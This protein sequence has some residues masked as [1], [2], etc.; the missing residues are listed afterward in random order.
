MN[1]DTVM[2]R[3]AKLVSQHG[4]QRAAAAAL[5]ISQ[6]H[7]CDMIHGRRRPGPKTLKALGLEE[8]V[9]YTVRKAP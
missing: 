7:F 1:L 5:G 2:E 8:T 9:V 6:P 4:S 3:L